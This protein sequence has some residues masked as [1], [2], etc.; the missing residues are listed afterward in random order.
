MLFRS[1]VAAVKW[2]VGAIKTVWHAL[3]SVLSAPFRALRKLVEG[4]FDWIL[5]AVRWLVDKVT[6]IL[7]KVLGPLGKVLGFAG[8]IAGGV[9]SVASSVGGFLG[10]AS[11]GT[12][13]APGVFT[14]G[15]AGPENVWLPSGSVVQPNPNGVG[16][17]VIH[18][19]LVVDGQV[20]AQ[21]VTRAGYK[22]LAMR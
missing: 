2:A 10:L 11:G 18:N 9:G 22:Q 19:Y 5:N 14:V 13:G 21:A 4:I 6:P 3:A 20:L 1:I 8:K 12:V 7:S 15:E 16:D 17:A